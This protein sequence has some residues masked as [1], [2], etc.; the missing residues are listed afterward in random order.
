MSVIYVLVFTPSEGDVQLW[1][2][3]RDK[4]KALWEALQLRT[5]L[6]SGTVEISVIQLESTQQA[7]DVDECVE[8]TF[9]QR[10]S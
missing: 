9:I 3:Y 6:I 7:T 1:G 10:R 5:I 2:G 8:A 4:Q